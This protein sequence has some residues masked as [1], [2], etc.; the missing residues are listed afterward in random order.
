M[1]KAE[2]VTNCSGPGLRFAQ[3][4][5]HKSER[6]PAPF[7]ARDASQMPPRCWSA[8]RAW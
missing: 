2:H 6:A 4:V 1:H 3:L 5:P 8:A 7:C